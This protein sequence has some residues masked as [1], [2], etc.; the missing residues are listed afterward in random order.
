MFR[1]IRFL[2]PLRMKMTKTEMLGALR[3]GNAV[4][5][6]E[7]KPRVLEEAS[8]KSAVADSLPEIISG[9]IHLDN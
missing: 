6:D 3:T 4:P 5:K 7:R 1:A 2:Q 9:R 8:E